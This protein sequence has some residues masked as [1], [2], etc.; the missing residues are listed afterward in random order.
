[1]ATGIGPVVYYPGKKGQNI[2]P[3]SE[4]N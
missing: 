2:L 4:P 3:Y 1:V